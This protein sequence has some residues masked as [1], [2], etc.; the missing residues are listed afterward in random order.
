[1]SSRH[2]W[3]HGELGAAHSRARS[4]RHCGVTA[5]RFGHGAGS[6]WDY[7]TREGTFLG[8]LSS[9]P[10]C[11]P[12][13][14]GPPSPRVGLRVRMERLPAET[15]RDVLACQ[16]CRDTDAGYVELCTRHETDELFRRIGA[17]SGMEEL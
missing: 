6:Y 5:R 7:T 4:C 13:P 10:A 17:F 2:S 16:D 3:D 1:M 9:V 8:V 11:P 12:E 14:P 15:Q